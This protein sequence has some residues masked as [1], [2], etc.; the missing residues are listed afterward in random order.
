M[1]VLHEADCS[2][3][4][5]AEPAFKLFADEFSAARDWLEANRKKN[6]EPCGRCRPRP[7]AAEIRRSRVARS[8][9][10]VVN[11]KSAYDVPSV[12]HEADCRAVARANP[13]ALV[14]FKDL[15]QAEVWLRSRLG[16]E[17]GKWSRCGIC[18]PRRRRS[19]VGATDRRTPPPALGADLLESIRKILEAAQTDAGGPNPEPAP[20]KPPRA[21]PHQPAS[22]AKQDPDLIAA[23]ERVADLSQ[24][25]TNVSTE[26]TRLATELERD[27]AAARTRAEDARQASDDLQQQRDD[28]KAAWGLVVEENDELR[29]RL[30]DVTTRLTGSA[31]D[32]AA[33][34]ADVDRLRRNG[35]SAD[36]SALATEAILSI[37]DRLARQGLLV[38][39]T[40]LEVI[41]DLLVAAP[42]ARLLRE[43]RGVALSSLNRDQEALA[44][45]SDGP[46]ALTAIGRQ[47]YVLSSVRVGRVV[48]DEK[49]WL[50]VDWTSESNRS[51][52]RESM[53]RMA[54]SNATAV[55]RSLRP[56]VPA[57]M[58]ATYL[59]DMFERELAD[60][61]LIRVL[62]LWG[63]IEPGE[64]SLRVLD[65]AERR[66]IADEAWM[67]AALVDA[68]QRNPSSER[69]AVLI[70]RR[71]GTRPLSEAVAQAV[72]VAGQLDGV[73]ELRF[74][75]AAA[76]KIA[77]NAITPDVNAQLVE[78]L[79]DVPGAWR[80]RGATA[81]AERAE[82]QLRRL[83]APDSSS[84]DSNRNGKIVTVE[85]AHAVLEAVADKYPHLV[86]LKDAY[87][88]AARWGRP[89]LSKL[90][91]TLEGIGRAAEEY[92]RKP[93]LDPW[94]A[95]KQVPCQFAGGV[96]ESAMDK[97]PAD[98]IREDGEGRVVTLGPH[99]IVGSKA[100]L[101]RIYLEIDEDLQRIVVG[102]VGAK[103]RD[104]TNPS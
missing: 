1:A 86:V 43:Y 84:V 41:D 24:Q 32:V 47:A 104:G 22:V 75:Q 31:T 65:V 37:A 93:D 88:S 40:G 44:A 49:L 79:R 67:D 4:S 11:D 103:L 60:N 5:A 70:A 99:F 36:E 91:K 72:R 64:A 21:Q 18:R 2:A 76:E 90:R 33:L 102:H 20:V 77:E 101:C 68:M 62:E 6:W 45:L 81:E 34:K 57:S 28:A 42:E 83:A 63:E 25:L 30:A 54:P 3:L 19:S 17:G 55:I 9:A 10:Y 95:I 27:R 82:A 78:L 8:I 50:T 52:L 58:L 74:R 80:A 69:P 89:N 61:D 29:A 23:R 35:P 100:N 73:I 15:D 46:T 7:K 14:E 92:A 97:Y 66:P 39:Q 96:S 71:L 48:D 59:D 13:S 98:Y 51:T 56:Q 12:L 94:V 26:V 53:V 38:G 85:S 16:P 87:V